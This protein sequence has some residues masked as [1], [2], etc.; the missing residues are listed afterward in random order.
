MAQEK[1]ASVETKSAAADDSVRGSERKSGPKDDKGKGPN[2]GPEMGAAEDKKTA[3]GNGSASKSVPAKANN[4]PVEA[5]RV[6]PGTDGE[7]P[8]IRR[9]PA[10]PARSR[11]AAN[12]DLPSIGGLIF[13]LQQRPSRQPFT[14]AMA[15]SAAWAVL[16]T[17][18]AGVAF[19]E[20]YSQ[21]NSI[22]GALASPVLLTTLATILLPIALFWF[23]ALLAWRS[24]ELRLVSSAMTEVAVRLAE[25]DRM[26]EQSVASLGQ[27]V[28]RQV[29][30]MNDAIARALGRAGELEALVHNEVAALERSYSENELRIRRLI[31]ELANERTML[32]NNSERMGD[33]IRGIGQQVAQ[34][35]HLASDQAT[36][37]LNVATENVADSFATKGE[38]VTSALRAAGAAIDER[39]THQG[40]Q[41]TDQLVQ[42]GSR[43]ADDLQRVGDQINNTLRQ[44][45]DETTALITAKGN[46]LLTSITSMHEKISREMPTLLEQLGGEQVRLSAIIGDAV[47]NL[48]A[49]ESAL[50]HQSGRIESTLTDRTAHLENVLTNHLRSVDKSLSDRTQMLD[51]AIG[52]RTRAIDA[53]LGERA[54]AFDAAL[55]QKAQLIDA[56]LVNRSQS[57]D[58]AFS[59]HVA[60]L[61]TS[62]SRQTEAITRALID[63]SQLIQS[64]LAEQASLLD[65]TFLKGVEAIRLTTDRLSNQSVDAIEALSSQAD[66][67]KSVAEGLLRQVGG[68]TQKF[69]N[70]GQA[71]MSAAQL[72]ETSGFKM[73]TVLESRRDELS[74]LLENIASKANELDAMMNSYSGKLENSLTSAQSRAKELSA[75][76]A[77]N[78]QERSKQ[79][80]AEIEMMRNHTTREAESAIADLRERF[81]AV[82]QQVTNQIGSLSSMF[83][84]S[85]KNLEKS[86]KSAAQQLAETQ[87]ELRQRIST[88]PEETSAN[89]QAMRQALSDQLRAMEE[90]NSIAHKHS[91]NRD[92]MSPVQPRTEQLSFDARPSGNGA[93]QAPSGRSGPGQ[94][95]GAGMPHNLD[96]VSA[97]IANTVAQQR[98][99]SENAAQHG[100]VN[101]PGATGP[102]NLSAPPGAMNA[103]PG[104]EGLPQGQPQDNA[105]WSMGDLLAR[106]SDEDIFDVDELQDPG[107]GAPRQG[108]A[109]ANAGAPLAQSSNQRPGGI[110]QQAAPGA[111]QMAQNR[112]PSLNIKAIA[113]AVSAERAQEIW[114]RYQGGER[115]LFSRELY[116]RDGQLIF[117]DTHRRLGFDKD[118]RVTVNRYLDDF[119]R[120]LTEADQKDPGGQLLSNY[121]NSDTGRAYLLLSHASGRL[122]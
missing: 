11:I 8:V 75:Q 72:L 86:T 59:Q 51:A 115:G 76:I 45:T 99:L 41:I 14:I 20:Q 79:A 89:A 37:A 87:A 62:I 111:P 110:P 4:K 2:K 65:Q 78:S 17:L 77:N 105:R 29:A 96:A 66:V 57:I 32:N 53:S 30:A 109:G 54:K 35:I 71:V 68:L 60:E 107:T 116:T 102:E 28:R 19:G 47:N 74:G 61:D 101:A 119:E 73:D 44:S 1:S 118:F 91:A 82:T 106:A 52:Q 48:S 5:A 56:S 122:S 43:V 88:L 25:P 64:T 95:A 81:S 46:T 92:I 34:D 117:D 31:D 55:H 13:A 120:L 113:Q 80:L 38:K 15:L 39:L 63:R 108:N 98:A 70:Q 121:L 114:S 100:D 83:T 85:T 9:R 3:S 50:T 103:G 42:Q 112:G 21:I 67:M 7:R 12:D 94:A 18:F 23:L 49:L 26:A 6:K 33:A 16:G 97:S 27:T 69:E 10:G 40:T 93:G 24:Q 104:A 58:A 90:L 36:Q 22:W 84:D